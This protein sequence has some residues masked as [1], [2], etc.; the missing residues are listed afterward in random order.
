M[1]RLYLLTGVIFEKLRQQHSTYAL[2]IA[3]TLELEMI[4]IASAATESKRIACNVPFEN[5]LFGYIHYCTEININLLLNTCNFHRKF[6]F[7]FSLNLSENT[8]NVHF[9][10]A[11]FQNFP[12]EHAPGPPSVLAPLALHPIF[13][14]LTLNCFRRGCYYQW[15]I[16]QIKL[17]IL[18]TQK[19][20]SFF[21]RKGCTF[22]IIHIYIF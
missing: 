19:D 20:V 6:R 15:V 11:Q 9:R 5:Q 1:L 4:N 21:S 7:V 17:R 18:I 3:A 14:G 16:L 22:R 2:A 8:Q 13:A 12:G 10:E